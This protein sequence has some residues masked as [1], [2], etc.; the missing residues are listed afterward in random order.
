MLSKVKSM[1]LNGLDGY[2][3]EIQTDVSAGLPT[4]E[5]VGLP[6]T[7]VREAKERIKAAIK[8]SG[9][10]FPSRRF[11]INLAPADIKKGGTSFDLPMA[12]GLLIS[13]GNINE[14]Q[15]DDLESTIFIGEVS[16]DGSIKS[17]NGVLPMCIEAMRLGIH[18]VI[19][20]K[21]NVKEASIV[22]NINIIPVNNLIEL[23]NHL[24]GISK[25]SHKNIDIDYLLNSK[26]VYNFDFA[27]VKGQ[28]NIK[29][30]L[31]IS[32]S[33]AH[34]CLLI[35]SPGSRQNN[36]GKTLTF[37]SSRFKL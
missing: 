16:L 34:N 32:A 19:L 2:L 35:G 20:P 11:L 26:T 22:K 14:H 1:A 6:D 8:N 31:E 30:A 21:D 28:E 18:N 36:D 17:V 33:G 13:T 23:V 27:D 5:V 10:E 9:F 37:Y 29:R 3:V 25:I 7:S 4:F 12:V 24:S 15:I